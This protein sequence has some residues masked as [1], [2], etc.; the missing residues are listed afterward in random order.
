MLDMKLEVDV[1]PVADIGRSTQ[2][3]ESLGWR[4][5]VTPPGIVQ[6]TPPGS[7]CSV[8]FGNN[9]TS[10]GPGSAKGYLIVDDIVAAR[11]KLTAANIPVSDLYHID[12]NGK[13]SGLDPD[14]NS[15]RS[16]IEFNDPDGN[17]WVFQ[18]V[19]TRLPGRIQ[20][21]ETTFSSISDLADAMRRASLAH[22][23][24][25][26]RIGHEDANWPD[27]YAAYMVAEESGAPLP[28]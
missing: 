27:W 20:A 19:T 10:A 12:Q 25:E 6:F 17:D 1:I 5:D 22:G 28:T 21:D 18:E 14:R 13:E 24:H 16:Y 2:F 23:E 11:D 4:K 8:M 15:Y 26:K 7:G 9:L 3:Y